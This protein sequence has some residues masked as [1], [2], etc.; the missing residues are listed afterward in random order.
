VYLSDRDLAWAIETGRLIVRPLPE[1]IDAT[2]IDLHLSRIEDA[3]IWNIDKFTKEVGLHGKPRP[4]VHIGQYVFG[5]FATKYT[6][7]PPEYEDD[8][9]HPVM[10][11]GH[12]I[13]V[14]SQG[15]LLW[16][17]E[18]E[19]GTPEENA[20]FICF[21]NGKSTKARAGMVVHLTAPTIHSSWKGVIVL[22][23]VNLGPFD[24]VFQAGDA[25]AQLTVSRITSPPAKTVVATSMTYGQTGIH[26]RGDS[27]ESL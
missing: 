5:Q 8:T 14:R 24:L 25:I 1:T 11:R 13:I 21:V 4:E 2:S 26:G 3:K 20:D 16:Q 6:M 12:E 18:E 23:I 7:S 17:T 27:P 15:F 9:T 10:R 19:V 22:E